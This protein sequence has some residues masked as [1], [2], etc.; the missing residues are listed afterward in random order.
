LL[1]FPSS[2]L[3]P[4]KD[5][6]NG[7]QKAGSWAVRETFVAVVIDNIPMIYPLLLRIFQ[8]VD[9][10]LASHYQ[11]RSKLSDQSYGKSNGSYA[12]HD[13]SKDRE[14]KSKYVHPL[15]MRNATLSGSA[16][17]IVRAERVKNGHDI[18]VVKESTVVLSTSRGSDEQILHY[19]VDG[20][21]AG[22]GYAVTCNSVGGDLMRDRDGRD[23]TTQWR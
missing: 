9:D 23:I 2:I 6:V 18:S 3:I 16:E 7:A 21:G 14:K 17:S 13:R 1:P 20:Q 4:H 19:P 5:P 22:M 11:S 15:S 8:K 10:T 12:M